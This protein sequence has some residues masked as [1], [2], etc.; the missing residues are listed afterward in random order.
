MPFCGECGASLNLELLCFSCHSPVLPDASF[1]PECGAPLAV[2]KVEQATSESESPTSK[3]NDPFSEK[4]QGINSIAPPATDHNK[5]MPG[6]P[7]HSTPDGIKKKQDDLAEAARIANA[8][9][10]SLA[11]MVSVENQKRQKEAEER[12]RIQEAEE[13]RKAEEIIRLAKIARLESEKASHI[14]ELEKKEGILKQKEAVIRDQSEAIQEQQGT[15]QRKDAEIAKLVSKNM[16]IINENKELKDKYTRI[17]TE[18]KRLEQ[19]GRHPK[20][21]CNFCGNLHNDPNE[22]AEPGLGGSWVFL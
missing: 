12:Q 6:N 3:S 14:R 13:R 2:A 8:M 22:C 19:Q 1:C 5:K 17:M 21:K 4:V 20:W 15:I 11:R 16:Q 18:K 10:G 7:P 9:A